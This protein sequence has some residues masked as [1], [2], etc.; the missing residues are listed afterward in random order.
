MKEK[1]LWWN[2]P[3][4]LKK[5]PE[6]W[7][8]WDYAAFTPSEV[9]KNEG[10]NIIFEMSAMQPDSRPILSPFEIDE[11]KYSSYQKLLR[12][13]AYTNR[14]I[15]NTKN[16]TRSNLHGKSELSAEELDNAELL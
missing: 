6:E 2:G 1:S 5:D 15:T 8:T 10:D 11:T 9:A 7:P 12:V 4:W 16:K 3:E 13:T 14:F